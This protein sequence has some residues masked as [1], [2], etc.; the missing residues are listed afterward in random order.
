MIWWVM[1]DLTFLTLCITGGGEC[2]RNV[3]FNSYPGHPPGVNKIIVYKCPVA[4]KIFSGEC[5]GAGK[6][7]LS[8]AREPGN[9]LTALPLKYRSYSQR[10]C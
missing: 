4:G 5:P 1:H 9:L 2:F 6:N 10:C 8:N 7:K 3:S